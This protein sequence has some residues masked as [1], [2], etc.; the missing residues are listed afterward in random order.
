MTTEERLRQLERQ[1]RRL[2]RV[3]L[4]LAVLALLPLLLAAG[5]ML[6][7]AGTVQAERYE[8][9]PKEGEAQNL[10]SLIEK[11]IMDGDQSTRDEIL[12][13]NDI[14]KEMPKVVY[15]SSRFEMDDA[16]GKHIFTSIPPDCITDV[17]FTKSEVS[18]K[19][20]DKAGFS[21]PLVLIAANGAAALAPDEQRISNVGRIVGHKFAGTQSALFPTPDSGKDGIYK[22]IALDPDMFVA[23]LPMKMY[24]IAVG[25]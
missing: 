21:V 22:Y 25:Q 17:Q 20:T 10:V 3:L 11:K 5:R 6:T 1:N 9:L 2:W 16:S 23:R 13:Q 12:K 8:L 24:F 4:C 7:V 19:F 15:I 18:F 14:I